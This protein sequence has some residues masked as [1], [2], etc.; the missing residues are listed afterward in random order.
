MVERRRILGSLGSRAKGA[1]RSCDRPGAVAG[2]DKGA[3]L[4]R[5]AGARSKSFAAGQL[6]AC[7]LFGR[8]KPLPPLDRILG[9]HPLLHAAEGQPSRHALASAA[10]AEGLPVLHVAPRERGRRGHRRRG[11][12]HR[13][14]CWPA[15]G[16]RSAPCCRRGPGRPGQSPWRARRRSTNLN[17]LRRLLALALSVHLRQ[18][19]PNFLVLHY[20]PGEALGDRAD[21]G[22]CQPGGDPL[23]IVHGDQ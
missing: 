4:R 21:T 13:P 3:H 22:D 15:L 11:V 9:S 1:L 14:G 8:P 16:G 23:Q 6:R 18:Y 20:R 17:R 7:A 12:A 2:G 10:E 19:K 5:F